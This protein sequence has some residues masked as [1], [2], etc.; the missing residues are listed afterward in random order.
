LRGSFFYPNPIGLIVGQ[1]SQTVGCFV[2]YS[3]YM[4]K[5]TIPKIPSITIDTPDK[6]TH[7]IPSVYVPVQKMNYVGVITLKNYIQKA[8]FMG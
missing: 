7:I 3:T 8:T 5:R 1:K 6:V 2:G 4:S